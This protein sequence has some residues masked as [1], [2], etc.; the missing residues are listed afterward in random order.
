MTSAVIAI[1][2]GPGLGWPW[3]TFVLLIGGIG[4]I[5]WF[6]R[7]QAT[8]SK[9]GTEPLVPLPLFKNRNYSLGAFSISTMGFAVASQML[10]IMMWFQT[11]R[12]S[13]ERREGREC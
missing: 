4:L 9:R 10:P 2:Q 5:V 13:E 7:L 1:Q 3:W 8:A 11:G 6:V 12:R